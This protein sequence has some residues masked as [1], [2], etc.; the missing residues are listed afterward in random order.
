MHMSVLTAMCR[1]Q[2]G[3]R[4]YDLS[5]WRDFNTTSHS[6]WFYFRYALYLQSRI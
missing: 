1:Q 4:T 2:T 5:V 6:Q 3:P